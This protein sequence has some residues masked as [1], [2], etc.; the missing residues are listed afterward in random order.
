MT[1]ISSGIRSSSG[2]Q[3][4]CKSPLDNQKNPPAAPNR[5]SKLLDPSSLRYSSF[6]TGPFIVVIESIDKNVGNLHPMALGLI[7][8]NMKICGIRQIDRRGANKVGVSFMNAKEAN[9]LLENEE[10]KRKGFKCYIPMAMLTCRGIIRGVYSALT[11]QQVLQHMESPQKVLDIRRLNRRKVVKQMSDERK[12]VDVVEYEPT[13]SVVVTF[14]GKLIPKKVYICHHP[15]NVHVFV[16][17][18]ILCRKCCRFGHSTSQCRGK[19]RCG[20]CL[21]EHNTYSCFAPA[22]KCIFCRQCHELFSRSCPEFVRQKKVKEAMV[23]ENIS[24]FEANKKYKRPFIYERGDFPPLRE[25]PNPFPVSETITVNER[26]QYTGVEVEHNYAK[27]ADAKPQSTP[28][29]RRAKKKRPNSPGYDKAAHRECLSQF[30]GPPENQPRRPSY[31]PGEP[32]SERHQNN[33]P[34]TRAPAKEYIHSQPANN[35]QQSD[36]WHDCSNDMQ[37]SMN[38]QDD[39]LSPD[40]RPGESQTSHALAAAEISSLQ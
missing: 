27:A 34:S 2:M 16:P 29:H 8:I 26:R 32:S 18:V 23:F 1:D 10:V 7:L 12:F 13:S 20:K 38:M 33:L 9:N 4:T 24:F 6:D 17:P 15:V 30:T 22:Y 19:E 25:P 31:A 36:C 37:L 5:A 40:V 11:E 35:S 39:D 21:E 14:A 28:L 3:D